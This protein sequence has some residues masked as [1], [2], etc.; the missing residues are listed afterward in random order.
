MTVPDVK[1]DR[2]TAELTTRELR[3]AL[4][5]TTSELTVAVP[6]KAALL[7]TDRALTVAVP[8]VLSAPETV[9]LPPL[10]GLRTILLLDAIWIFPEAVLID[11]SGTVVGDPVNTARMK[12]PEPPVPP[13]VVFLPPPPPPDPLFEVALP[14]DV[15]ALIP[16]LP[17][18]PPPPKA[19]VPSVPAPPPP[20]YAFPVIGNVIAD[21]PTPL[22]SPAIPTLPIPPPPP[23]EVVVLPPFPPLN[24]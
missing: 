10:E 19:P 11:P 6:V 7:V 8:V 4:L 9:T 2:V 14:P 17:A 24:P 15:P 20:P 18:P 12:I 16:P 1:L 22:T 21:P 5:D 23:P 13:F 3:V